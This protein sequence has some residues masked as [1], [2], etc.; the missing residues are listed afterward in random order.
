MRKI[1]IL[2]LLFTATPAFSA[3]ERLYTACNLWF[4][5]PGEM[6]FINYKVGDILPA[7]TE[8]RLLE[9]VVE[10]PDGEYR[11]R[12]ST[13]GFTPYV[14]FETVKEGKIFK[15]TFQN[16]YH[17]DKTLQDYTSLYFSKKNF[18]ELT[19]GMTSREIYAIKRGFL[20]EGMSKQAVLISY[21]YPPEHKTRSLEES[22]WYYWP[23]RLRYKVIYFD[24]AGKT[25]NVL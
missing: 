10:P 21:G 1:L 23:D 4:E 12:V 2:L 7:G 3:Q 6:H 13:P 20:V 25:I 19:N 8:V 22:E 15:I 5:S 24:D 11:G 9:V 16:N 17:P 18:D 14:K